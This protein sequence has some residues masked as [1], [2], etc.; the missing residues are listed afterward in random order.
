MMTNL[1]AQLLLITFMAITSAQTCTLCPEGEPPRN[2]DVAVYQLNDVLLSCKT[3]AQDLLENPPVIC[4]SEYLYAVQNICGCCGVKSGT[5]PGICATGSVLTN[6]AQVT[7]LLGGTCLGVNQFL[8]GKPGATTC[9][10]ISAFNYK[11]VCTCKVKV[12]PSP[13]NM[14]GGGMMGMSSGCQLRNGGLEE[15]FPPRSTRGLSM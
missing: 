3:I 7:N 6:P 9:P 2:G 14:G 12:T 13:N 11:E 1:L 10:D 4:D 15:Y 5:C 8:K